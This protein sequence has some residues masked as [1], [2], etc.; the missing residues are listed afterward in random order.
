MNEKIK[1]VL[2]KIEELNGSERKFW[3]IPKSTAK[4]LRFLIIASN[5]KTVLEFGCSIGYSAIWMASAADHVYT[6]EVDE[7][8][9]E[10]ADENFKE[11]GVDAKITLYQEDIMDVIA[12]WK[13]SIDF[14][15]IDA[16]KK[17]YLSYYEHVMPLL[18]SGGLIVADNCISH[19]NAMRD[20]LDKVVIDS[21]VSATLL[22]VDNGLMLIC[23]K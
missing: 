7:E 8:R 11:A 5:S 9:A 1:K 13:I 14:V 10:L 4:F 15:F 21:R 2:N 22:D 3:C 17:Q 20:F 18:K 19:A 12:R 16:A 23:K 6:T